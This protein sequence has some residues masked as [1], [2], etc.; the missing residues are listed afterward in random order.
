MRL[1]GKPNQVVQKRIRK[2]NGKMKVVQWFKFDAEGIA[3][4]EATPVER[5]RLLNRFVE[6]DSSHSKPKGSVLSY[7]ELQKM[8]TDKTGKK[9]VGVKK[10][11]MLKEL[12]Y[13]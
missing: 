7:K 13:E 5:V 4:V 2:P 10:A 12:G 9:A 8:Y 3:E 11:D 1:K 6:A